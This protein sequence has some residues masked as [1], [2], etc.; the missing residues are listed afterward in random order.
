MGHVS[1]SLTYIGNVRTVIYQLAMTYLK[2]VVLVNSKYMYNKSHSVEQNGHIKLMA[3]TREH[4]S[5]LRYKL[6]RDR[7]ISM[8]DKIE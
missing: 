1:I 4:Y 8:I 3:E 5:E 6:S 2:R 7:N